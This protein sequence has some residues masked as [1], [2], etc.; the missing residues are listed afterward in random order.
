MPKI[1]LE[2]T[3]AAIATPVGEGGISVIRLSGKDAFP[4]LER[5]FSLKKGKLSQLPSHTIHFGKILNDKKEVVDEVLASLFRAP[6]SYTAQDVIEISSH[7]GLLVTKSIL[8][9][10]I[11]KGARHA[12]PG[13]FTKRAFLNGKIDL[14]QAEAILDLIRA[15]SE[16][17]RECAVRQL[18]GDLSR[19]FKSIKDELLKMH[20]HMEAFLDFPD[21]H[22]EIYSDRVF[23]DQFTKL[24]NDLQELIASF[25]RGS[26]LREGAVVAIAGKPNVGKSSLFNTLLARDRALVS[27]LPGTTRDSLEEAVE[28]GGIYMRL[29]DTAGLAAGLE[30]PLDRMGMERTRQV[31]GQTRF[32][33]YLLDG[34]GEI[35]EADR[36][37][38]REILSNDKP[39]ENFSNRKAIIVLN[40]CDLGIKIKEEDIRKFAGDKNILKISTKTREGLEMLEAAMSRMVTE[41]FGEGEGEQ[42]TRLRHK[43]ALEE[44]L[45]ALRRSREAFLR[46]DSLEFAVVDLKEAIDLLRELVGEVYSED[47]LDVIFSEF[48][49]GK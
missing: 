33:L 29:V 11:S 5:V 16:K 38:Y 36:A 13:E 19:R 2:D 12:E 22:L 37:A 6:H 30:N 42:V 45:S 35:T 41:G 20:A 4:I 43:N 46:K 39:A 9:L 27:E 18:A 47:L 10:L 17:S 48:C 34:S 14:A 24:E 1:D 28:I 3:I 40:K 21:E 7:G 8:D 49:I 25:R 32:F 15:K 31:L 23:Q 26:V 44:S